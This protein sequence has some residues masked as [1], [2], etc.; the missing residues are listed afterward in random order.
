MKKILIDLNVV[1]IGSW[2]KA[3]PSRAVAENFMKKIGEKAGA[4]E[5]KQFYVV[6]P[7][8]LLELVNKWKNKPLVEIITDFY[9]KVT[10]EYVEKIDVMEELFET[11]EEVYTALIRIGVKPEDAFLVIVC[12]VKNAALVTFDKKHLRGKDAEINAV[13]RGHICGEVEIKLPEELISGLEFGSKPSEL[14][15]VFKNPF[16]HPLL[17]FAGK[18]DGVNV[19]RDNVFSLFHAFLSFGFHALNCYFYIYKP[20]HK[21]VSAYKGVFGKSLAI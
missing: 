11:F 8:V 6:T 13:L 17:Y 20:F 2:K 12:S 19:F 3:D 21:I 10:D 1:T 9:R 4:E 7:Y 14:A 5:E 16:A 18:L 15:V